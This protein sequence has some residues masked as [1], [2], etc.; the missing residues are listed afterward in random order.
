[1]FFGVVCVVWGVLGG[2]WGLVCV[3]KFLGS[4]KKKKK[5]KKR[6]RLLCGSL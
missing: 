6:R 3:L 1:L 5:K 2:V 4:K